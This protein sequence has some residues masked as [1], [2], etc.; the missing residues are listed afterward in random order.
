MRTQHPLLP[1][2]L[3]AAGAVALSACTVG[4]DFLRPKAP[5]GAGYTPEKLT[6]K[7]ASASVTGGIAQGFMVGADIPGQWWTLFHSPALD[8]LIKEALQANPSL[9]AA[10]AALRQAN[11]IVYAD[12]GGQFPTLTANGSA[13][14]E[15]I[16]AAGTGLSTAFSNGASL[17]IPPFNVTSASLNISYAPDVFGGVRRE[18]EFGGCSGRLRTLRT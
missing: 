18:V 4:P 12:Q 9:A 2:L 15:R 14:R 6:A 5:A 10:Q 1:I 3:G 16:S 11:E 13:T 7:T 8:A 17:R